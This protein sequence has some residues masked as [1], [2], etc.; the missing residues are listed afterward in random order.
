MSEKQKLNIKNV[1]KLNDTTNIQMELLVINN[2][3]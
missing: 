1:I 2:G 3:T